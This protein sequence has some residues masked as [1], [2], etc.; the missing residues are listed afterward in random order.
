MQI[1]VLVDEI[2]DQSCEKILDYYNYNK[3]YD[4]EPLER[5]DRCEGGFKIQISYMKEQFCDENKKIKQLRWHKKYLT[6]QKYIDFKYK[7]KMLLFESLV[8]VLGSDN[9]SLEE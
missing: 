9:V 3:P 1:K 5:L 2:D 4:E 6:S 8:N 7:E